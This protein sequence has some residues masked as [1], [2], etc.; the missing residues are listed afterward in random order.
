MEKK[1]LI[2]D[3]EPLAL[4]HYFEDLS[5]IP[6][7]SCH[8]AAAAAYV[9]SIAKTH[10]LW[11]YEDEIHNVLVRKP[12]SRGCEELPPVLLEGHLD[13]VGEKTAD[14]T[15]N[16][17]TD[18]LELIVE[19]NILCA[20]N[21]TLGAD[22][23]CA[24]A[25]MLKILTDDALVHPPVECLFTVQEE[26]GLI[27]AKYFDASRLQSRRVIG[28]DAGSEGVFRMGT[29]TKLEMT[30]LYP[31]RREPLAGT[32]YRLTVAGLRGGDQG[33]GIPLERICAI[34]MTAR[35]L[36]H[37]NK[38]LDVRIISVDKVGK[39]I[40]EDC[41]SYV[42]LAE[43]SADRLQQ[44]LQEQQALIRKEYAE[45]DPDITITAAEEK[46]DLPMLVKEDNMQLIRA[47]YLMPYGAQN[48]SLSRVDE[49]SCSVI[50]KK[51]YTQ[52][53]GIRIFSVVSTE[54]MEQGEA[55]N[56]KLKTFLSCFGFRLE[57]LHLNKGWDWSPDSP[58]RDTMVQAYEELFGRKP[59]VNIS[60]GGNDCVVLKEK[61]PELD[62]VT[63][64]ATYVDF[65]TPKE[66]LY[67]DT[68]EKVMALLERT[69]Q[70]LAKG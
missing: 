6:R 65:H 35:V 31:A 51:I 33:A 1:Y 18:P 20:N 13:M 16:F 44:I 9:V 43:G 40:P 30:S 28:L 54:Q 55:V 42:A 36:H 32:V 39:S 34:K 69:L 11:Y 49:V 25:M 47:L 50:L 56:E 5:A 4:Y 14:S 7:V 3:R 53:D 23:G 29:S 26:T 15:H 8:E 48:R 27:G 21:T 24:V 61:I 67:M 59:K 19:G 57:D 58:I 52:E 41:L 63:T 12:G 66:R 22:N 45:S 38:E 37:L 64:A 46:K 62:M 68:F 17:D 60:H 2:T 70:L 10:G